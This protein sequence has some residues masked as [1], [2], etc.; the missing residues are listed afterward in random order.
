MPAMSTMPNAFPPEQVELLNSVGPRL[1]RL[2]DAVIKLENSL[3]NQDDKLEFVISEPDSSSEET[4]SQLNSRLERV[5]DSLESVSSRLARSEITTTRKLRQE[6]EEGRKSK[7]A[8]NNAISSSPSS[9]LSSVPKQLYK[10][11]LGEPPKFSGSRKECRAFLTHL[12][13]YFKAYEAWFPDDTSKIIF[14]TSYLTSAAFRFMIPFI[15]SLDVPIGYRSEIMTNYEAFTEALT[16]RF[17][18]PA[19]VTVEENGLTLVKL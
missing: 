13:L 6:E 17:G 11:K 8:K 19:L 5:E 2:E 1:E 10:F 18:F 9:S 7:I 4:L 14:A 16:R 15:D 12:N 3:A